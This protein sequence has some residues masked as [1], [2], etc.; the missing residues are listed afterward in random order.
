MSHKS[1][2]SFKG[3]GENGKIGNGIKLMHRD[4]ANLTN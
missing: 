4:E 2:I 3:L 1:L